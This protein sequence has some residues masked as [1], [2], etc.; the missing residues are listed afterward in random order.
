MQD[1][2]KG[3]ES[4]G[5]GDFCPAVFVSV[6]FCFSDPFSTMTLV[7]FVDYCL[8]DTFL[9]SRK[10]LSAEEAALVAPAPTPA[11]APEISTD[12]YKQ[13]MKLLYKLIQEK[14]QVSSVFITVLLNY[15][16]GMTKRRT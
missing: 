8:P 9:Y 10:E 14:Y 11:P 13:F 7:V 16:L 12:R 2:G 6:L 1:H 4:V 5:P 15:S 3:S